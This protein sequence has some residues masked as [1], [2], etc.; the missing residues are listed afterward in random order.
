[1]NLT[2]HPCTPDDC[3]DLARL[4]IEGWRSSYGGLV[5]QAYLDGLDTTARAQDWRGWL[6][7][8][9][10]AIIARD[11]DGNGCGFVAFSKLM[12]PPP[13]M[14]PVRPLY[15]A[16]IL[17]IY[18]L[19]AYWRV[20]LGRRLMAAAAESLRGDKHKSLCLWVLEKNT[21]AVSFYKALGGERCGKKQVEIGGRTF[22]DVAFG[23]RDS[24]KLFPGG[25]QGAQAP[26]QTIHN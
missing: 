12:T 20:G 22:T 16:E 2:L 23:W 26:K 10:R 6:A 4:H 11:A 25:G 8:G 15:T 14:S 18:I 19:P 24:G 5:D 9:T 3:D 21:R 1:M 7:G 13:G 17:A